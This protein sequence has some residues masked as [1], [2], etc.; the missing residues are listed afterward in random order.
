[1]ANRNAR[2]VLKGDWTEM[3]EPAPLIACFDESSLLSCL[4]GLPP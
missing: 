4:T 1:M 2:A 3:V